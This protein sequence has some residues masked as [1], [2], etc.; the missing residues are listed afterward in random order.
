MG[1]RFLMGF[2]IF[3]ILDIVVLLLEGGGERSHHHNHSGGT[4]NIKQASSNTNNSP[5]SQWRISCSF[6][7]PI[8]SPMD[9]I[10]GKYCI[11][12]SCG[13]HRPLHVCL[14]STCTT[15]LPAI[16][17]T[18]VSMYGRLM[19]MCSFGL[20]LWKTAMNKQLFKDEAHLNYITHLLEK[21]IIQSQSRENKLNQSYCLCVL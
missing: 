10:V 3:S 8:F 6:A 13:W 21:V 5:K 16:L 17:E 20:G 18:E 2:G 11:H 4:K 15:T 9:S 7:V 19:Q 12:M 14:P 1:L